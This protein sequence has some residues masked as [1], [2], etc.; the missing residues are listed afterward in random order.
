MRKEFATAIAGEA[1]RDERIVLLTGDLGFQAL[2]GV[3]DRMQGRF[4]NAGV[5]EQNMVGVA[6]GLASSGL[7]PWAYSIAPFMVLRPLEQIRNDVC[8]HRLPVKFVGN[9]G[10]YGYGIMGPTHHMLED[11][12]CL[13]G[14]PNMRV[15][16]PYV[17]SDVAEAVAAL[18]QDS[19]P[20]YLRLGLGAALGPLAS[21]R[22]FAAWRCLH[23]AGE[24]RLVVVGIGP[25]LGGAVQAA[26]RYL[27]S[28]D[29]WCVGELPLQ[30]LP[31]ACVD[32]IASARAL[33]CVEEH[34]AHGGMA[35]ALLLSLGRAGVAPK[36]VIHAC[37]R[38][39]PSR[40]Y[41]T[42]AFHLKESGLD[43]PSF[44]RLFQELLG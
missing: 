30:P 13:S 27:G 10:G 9:G 8:L 7:R 39:Y 17:A 18:A 42:Q 25:A 38:G 29:L 34:Y 22:P 14:L 16:V 5:A 21:V 19:G 26:A 31:A 4:I 6:A 41:G 43:E 20:G 11:F 24:P 40:T 44:A 36:R 32:A 28:I 15:Q 23:S 37:A 35:G 1:M 3:Q 33:I 12:A 2:E